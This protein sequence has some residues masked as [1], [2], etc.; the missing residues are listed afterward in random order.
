MKTFRKISTNPVFV[1]LLTAT[2]LFASCSKGN[3]NSNP[4]Q[5]TSGKELFKS[6]IFVDGSLTASIPALDEINFTQ[7]LPIDQLLEFREFEDKALMYLESKDAQYF[8][9]FKQNILSSDVELIAKTLKNASNDM[10]PLLRTYAQTK[11]IDFENIDTDVLKQSKSVM[12]KNAEEEACLAIVIVLGV[13]CWA[14]SD[15]CL[16]DDAASLADE[17]GIINNTIAAQLVDLSNE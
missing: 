6:I 11:S 1:F 9:N 4:V 3:V 2:F 5:E 13:F 8:E 12:V 14:F 7:N 17:Q 16:P 10:S 15:F